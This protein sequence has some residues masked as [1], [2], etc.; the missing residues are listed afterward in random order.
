MVFLPLDFEGL[1]SDSHV[2]ELI[3]IPTVIY[4]RFFFFFVAYPAFLF[5]VSL[6]MA[7]LCGVK[8][9]SMLF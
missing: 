7:I 5:F 6:V 2:S 9:I 1:H 4:K 3:Y 8:K